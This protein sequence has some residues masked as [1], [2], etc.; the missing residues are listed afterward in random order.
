MICAQI[1]C[2]DLNK[3]VEADQRNSLG[4]HRRLAGCVLG[5]PHMDRGFHELS[6]TNEPYVLTRVPP[7]PDRLV[8]VC[9]VKGGNQV[10]GLAAKPS[11]RIRTAVLGTGID[12]GAS[13][14]QAL[15]DDL[16]PEPLDVAEMLSEVAHRP[17]R[18]VFD[19]GVRVQFGEIG[20]TV[21]QSGKVRR[22]QPAT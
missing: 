13:C 8:V 2:H 12:D 4:Q 16:R 9:V 17:V 14:Q 15:P 6:T 21:R 22:H 10:R 3:L 5:V 19:S 7:R 11:E 20:Q 18:T 1:I